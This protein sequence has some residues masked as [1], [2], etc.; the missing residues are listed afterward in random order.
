MT[1]EVSCKHNYLMTILPIRILKII[2]LIPVPTPFSYN[3]QPR[4][5]FMYLKFQ[6]LLSYSIIMY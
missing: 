5:F 6:S 4:S 3:Y 1:L 2:Q